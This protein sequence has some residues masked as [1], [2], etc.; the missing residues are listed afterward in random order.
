M[1]VTQKSQN[2]Q[3]YVGKFP[4]NVYHENACY[5]SPVHFQD[6]VSKYFAPF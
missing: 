4:E 5:S 6:F 1:I 2:H 3:F